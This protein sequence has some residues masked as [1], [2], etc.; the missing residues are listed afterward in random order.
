MTSQPVDPTASATPAPATQRTITVRHAPKY[1]PFMIAGAIFAVVVAGF[2]AAIS[3][4][5]EDF[6]F[7]SIFGFFAVL[8]ILPGAGLGAA[9]ALAI[10]RQ[11]VRRSRTAVVVS[12]PD[13]KADEEIV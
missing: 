13:D 8:L 4:G 1:V 11:S 2:L 12:V 7:S 5:R 10:D 9:V 3:P 6:E